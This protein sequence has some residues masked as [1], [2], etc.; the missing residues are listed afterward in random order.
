MLEY[1]EVK[2]RPFLLALEKALKE[3]QVRSKTVGLVVIDITNLG[4]IN[5]LYGHNVGDISLGTVF[6]RLDATTSERNNVFRI[7]SHHFAFLLPTIKNSA[8][9]TLAAN[10]LRAL[11]A[12]PLDVGQREVHLEVEVGVATSVDGCDPADA[13]LT[14]AETSLENSK[15]EETYHLVEKDE[16]SVVRAKGRIELEQEFSASLRDD[17]F[18]LFY[19]PKVNLQTGAVDSCEALL[20]WPREDGTYFPAGAAVE[21]AESL[22]LGYAL[23]KWVL[24][25]AIRQAHRWHED[26][27]VAIAVNIEA[28]LIDS[29]D[30]Y[31]LVADTVSIWGIE[32]NMI[33]LEVTESAVLGDQGSSFENLRKLREFGIG[34]AIDDFGTGYSSLSY[35]KDIPAQELKID[36]SFIADMHEETQ[37]RELVDIMIQIAHLFGMRAVGE[38]VEN[39]AVLEGLR[40]GG[41]DCAQGYYFS[42]PLP[43]GEFEAWLKQWPGLGS[44]T[45]SQR[46]R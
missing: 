4:R 19:Q 22:K 23:S 43:A 39:A 17:A 35:F 25:Q 42:E 14:I 45:G 40:A 8:L 9:I 7:A 18:E 11:L 10:R 29:P 15:G 12:E 46:L 32:E 5:K 36:Q 33:T 3:A 38:G 28:N 30:L 2:R 34:L 31:N 41:C 13:L 27:Q 26:H 24:G 6:K 20:R 37:H 1:P 44:Y 16:D 21:I